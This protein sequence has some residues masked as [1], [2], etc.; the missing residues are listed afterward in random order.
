[1]HDNWAFQVDWCPCNPNLFATAFFDGI[2][3]IHSIQSTNESSTQPAT[4]KPDTVSSIRAD[5]ESTTTVPSFFSDDAGPGTC[6][7]IFLG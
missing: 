6:K 4:T 3:G 5:N 7:G 2:I 1:L